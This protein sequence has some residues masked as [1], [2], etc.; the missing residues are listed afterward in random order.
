MRVRFILL[1]SLFT[2]IITACAPEVRIL[3]DKLLQDTSIVTDEPCAAP[4]WRG[5]TPGETKWNDALA[6]LE[7]DETLTDL[8]VR[9]NADTGQIGAAWSV[10]NGDRCCQMFTQDSETVDLIVLSTTPDLTFGQLIEKY[11]EPEY[12]IGQ[13][14]ASTQALASLYYLDVPMMIYLYAEGESGTINDSSPV[15]GFAYTTP[16][17]MK[18]VVDTS[19]LYDWNGF[20]IF[21]DL[22][23]GEF[24]L[25]ATVTLTPINQ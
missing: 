9:S 18:L 8:Q 7:A 1:A 5:I 15:V 3:S 21:S 22:V 2:L 16:E 24:D 10:T 6:I 12:I 11:G 19:N 20:G 13:S 14:L 17:L 4:C 23:S 25:T